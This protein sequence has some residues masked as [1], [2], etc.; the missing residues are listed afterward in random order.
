MAFNLA[1]ITASIRGLASQAR[2]LRSD[3]EKAR[4]EHDEIAAAPAARADLKAALHA[5]VDTSAEKFDALVVRALQPLLTRPA[6]LH[7]GERVAE[8]FGLLAAAAPGGAPTPRAHDLVVCGL[9]R[10]LALSGLDSIVDAMTWPQPEGLP[11]AQRVVELQRLEKHIA[12]LEAQEAT[13]RAE[14]RAGGVLLQD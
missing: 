1:D 6:R 2:K 7:D 11:M 14:A 3:I 8:M 13:L 4:R 5:Y 9:A 10:A 12:G